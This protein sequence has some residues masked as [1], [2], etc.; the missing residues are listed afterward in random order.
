MLPS[1]AVT[2]LS[3]ALPALEAAGAIG[4]LFADTR[5]VSAIVLAALFVLFGAA[6]EGAPNRGTRLRVGRG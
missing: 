3:F 4:V 6:G 5:M 2:P 1:F